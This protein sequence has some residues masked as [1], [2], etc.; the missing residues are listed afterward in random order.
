MKDDKHKQSLPPEVR[1]AA[2]GK[3]NELRDILAPYVTPLTPEERR[4][5]PKMGGRTFGFVEKAFDFARQNSRFVPPYLD[6]DAFGAD[7]ADAHGLWTLRNAARQIEEGIDD[8]VM[9][10]GSE[11]YRAALLFYQSVK[12]AANAGISGAEAV[13]EELKKHFPQPGRPPKN[14]APA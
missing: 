3:L 1:Q 14:T 13:Y 5:L 8:T 10:A 6:M 4:K 7:F 9:T 2:Q 11:S 12:T